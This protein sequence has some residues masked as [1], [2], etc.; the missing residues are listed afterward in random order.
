M[1]KSQEDRLTSIRRIQ[2]FLDENAALLG[3]IN[4]STSRMDLGAAV[5]GLARFTAKQALA[6]QEMT[7]RTKENSAVSVS[8]R[9]TAPASSAMP[10]QRGRRGAT[11]RAGS[12]KSGRLAR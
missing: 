11:V 1:N 3:T 4:K 12:P 8:F 7:A 2:A 5:T 9:E 6:E 10:G